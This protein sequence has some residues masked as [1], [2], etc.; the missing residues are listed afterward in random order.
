MDFT[1]VNLGT[2]IGENVE[3]YLRGLNKQLPQNNITWAVKSG[4][5]TK[6][7]VSGGLGL[8]LMQEFIYY[9][10]GKYQ[11]V[12]GNEFWEL[13]NRSVGEEKFNESFPGTIINIEI[14]QNDTSFYKYKKFMIRIFFKGGKNDYTNC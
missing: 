1:I 5:S 7:E 11:I 14:D 3:K 10:E 13:N 2:T 12:S 6:I 4:N 9:N 8:S